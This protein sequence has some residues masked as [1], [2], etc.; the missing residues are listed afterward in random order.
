M[1]TLGG[2]KFQVSC[3]IELVHQRL[4]S[5]LEIVI[6]TININADDPHKL[7]PYGKSFNMYM[8]TSRDCNCLGTGVSYL[9]LPGR[10]RWI[11]HVQGS[12]QEREREWECGM[13]Y[14]PSYSMI[15]LGFHSYNV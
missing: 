14:S 7:F 8:N 5:T 13:P 1:K 15:G 12:A 3:P 4:V 6:G 11:E 10:W 2:L 9:L